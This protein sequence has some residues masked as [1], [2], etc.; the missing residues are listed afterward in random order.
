MQKPGIGVSRLSNSMNSRDL[1][2]KEINFY[3]FL[4]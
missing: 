4:P 1:A 2:S 3:L